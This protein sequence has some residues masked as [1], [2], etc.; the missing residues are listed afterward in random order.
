LKKSDEAS[1]KVVCQAWLAMHFWQ[2][3]YFEMNLR[4][5]RAL[6]QFAEIHFGVGEGK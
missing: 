2:I 4:Q 6:R 1:P 3:T 5:V